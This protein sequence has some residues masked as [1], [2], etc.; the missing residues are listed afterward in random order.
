MT[1]KELHNLEKYMRVN[2]HKYRRIGGKIELGEVEFAGKLID[3]PKMGKYRVQI[4]ASWGSTSGWYSLD[5][6]SLWT[7][8]GL[9]LRDAGYTGV[10]TEHQ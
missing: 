9:S 4:E 5:E 3:G 7:A 6:L 8:P 10:V 1:S 2:V